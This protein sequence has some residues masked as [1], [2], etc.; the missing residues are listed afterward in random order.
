MYVDRDNMKMI[1]KDESLHNHENEPESVRNKNNF[2]NQLKRKC[3]DELSDRQ[4]L[5]TT[6]FKNILNIL[7]CLLVLM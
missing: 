1:V 2:S 5:S 7:N 6:K 3:E 4:K